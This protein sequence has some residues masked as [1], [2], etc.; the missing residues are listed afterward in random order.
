MKMLPFD[1]KSEFQVVVDMPEGTPVEQTNRVL[2]R[3]GR[4]TWLR[5]GSHA[6]VRPTPAPRSR[7]T[8]MAWCVSTTCAASRTVGDVQVN[9][10][11]KHDRAAQEP[12]HCPRG[13]RSA[14]GHRC[15]TYGANVKVVEVP[16][17]PPVHG[18]AGGRDLRLDYADRC[19]WPGGCVQGAC[20]SSTDGVVDVDDS[21]RRRQRQVWC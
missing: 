5:A 14:A 13:A 2:Q 17:G 3:P 6:T 8:S 7:S 21:S 1:N 11:D 19:R 20:S 9:L 18:A 10:V 15:A 12:R 16:P 4:L